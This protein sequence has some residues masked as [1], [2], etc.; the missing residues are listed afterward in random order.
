MLPNDDLARWGEPPTDA[1]ELELAELLAAFLERGPSHEETAS[2]V[3]R[4][5]DAAE[6][7]QAC[8]WIDE[9]MA[10]VAEGSGLLAGAGAVELRLAV[11]QL[12]GGA[13]QPVA[14]THARPCVVRDLRRIPEDPNRVT[15]R[16]GDRV[17]VEVT[18]D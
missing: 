4:A 17:R 12:V 8:H 14:S 6:L 2:R 10:T 9:M 5:S 15:L 11:S 1:R 7:V 18:C 13:Y 3:R 16:T